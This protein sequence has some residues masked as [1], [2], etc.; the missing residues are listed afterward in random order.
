MKQVILNSLTLCNFKG[1]HNRTT[2]FNADITTISGANGL[3]KSRHFDAFLWL[4]FGKDKENR[5]DYEVKTH[6]AN[7]NTQPQVDV[8]I[9]GELTVNGEHIKLTRKLVE[10]WVTP[11]M[12]N[13]SVF[14]GN[15][16]RC[17]WNDVPVSV[18]EYNNRVS[19]IVNEQLFKMVTNP[20][21]FASLNWKNQ[22]E[23]LFAMA[24]NIS[25]DD[26]AAKNAD[27][28]TLLDKLTGKSFDDYK[29]EIAAKKRALR[30]ELSE[31]QPRIDQ[32][33]RMKPETHD[34]K[35]I[36]KELAACD[37]AIA[38]IDNAIAELNR[39]M[40]DRTAAAN[41]RFEETKQLHRDLM[42]CATRMDLYVNEAAR[43]ESRR[44]LDAN[45]GV[46]NLALELS[47]RKSALEYRNKRIPTA[48]VQLEAIEAQII[49]LNEQRENKRTEWFE[50]DKRQ[51]TGD[52][53]CPSCGQPI[54]EEMRA[55]SRAKFAEA[56][57]IDLDNI[58]AEGKKLTERINALVKDKE[59]HTEEIA[60]WTSEIEGIKVEI[61][62]LESKI[63]NAS[64]EREKDIDPNTIPEWVDAKRVYD[65]LSAKIA[66]AEKNTGEDFD[67]TEINARLAEKNAEKATLNQSRDAIMNKL[68]DRIMIDKAD[69]EI[70]SLNE[71]GRKLAQE[72]ADIER[73]EY[74]I[75]QFTK[76]K[77]DLVES[78]VGKLFKVVKFKMF[79]YTI[80][81]N[82]IETCVAMV[83]GV[84]FPTINSAMQI[85]AGLD[86]IN[87]LC[88]H[89]D[90]TAPIFIDNRESVNELI[91]T[92]SQI[93]NL[94][95]TND[96]ELV[97]S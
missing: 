4:L 87:A 12:T 16:T 90:V 9:T 20:L 36:E 94:V 47:N 62:E 56:K 52:D 3:G 41:A 67:K 79:D 49:K 97:I 8:V 63:A 19:G 37:S 24:G 32:T 91:P 77:V 25:D 46:D 59:T 57:R 71:S 51:Y 39:A 58:T 60:K 66:D 55:A 40:T 70:A 64:V 33:E 68:N 45:K 54:P 72:I 1:E 73:D 76:A 82:T 21:F 6:D 43:A 78:R 11:K 48:T 85:N 18:T 42:H 61:A 27:F 31:I 75:G 83:N 74:T 88:K 44:V 95:V 13:E 84:P 38:E 93:I 65:E 10:I 23:Q 53:I 15:E 5:A 96:P 29:A 2:S 35:A 22:R 28:R 7:G 26:I 80:D 14:K 34:W 92:A 30:K 81:G 69:K 86:I 89:Y 50:I 17:L